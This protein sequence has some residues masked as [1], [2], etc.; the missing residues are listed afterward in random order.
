[1]VAQEGQIFLRFFLTIC[2]LFVYLF[3]F[4]C[5]LYNSSFLVLFYVFVWCIECVFLSCHIRI[6]NETGSSPVAVT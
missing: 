6:Q 2:F 4:Y 1:M 5:V 3:N